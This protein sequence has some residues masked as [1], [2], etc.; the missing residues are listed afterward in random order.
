MM[1]N[2]PALMPQLEGNCKKKKKVKGIKNVNVTKFCGGLSMI[3]N[4]FNFY[5]FNSGC[6]GLHYNGL[7]LFAVSGATFSC[8]AWTLAVASV[9]EGAQAQ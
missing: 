8:G 4:F 3:F 9:G 6:L 5:V 7:S 1:V 2:R